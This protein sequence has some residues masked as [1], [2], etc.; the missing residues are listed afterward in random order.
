[1]TGRA[2]LRDLRRALTLACSLAGI[3][4]GTVFYAGHVDVE[5][6]PMTASCTVATCNLGPLS[7]PTDDS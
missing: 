4:S 3:I 1:M 5:S 6:P 2:S 7:S